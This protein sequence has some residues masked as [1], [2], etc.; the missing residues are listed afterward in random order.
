M[1]L[2]LDQIRRVAPSVFADRPW[3]EVS[4]RYSFIPTLHVVESLLDDGF[5][6]S[7]ARQSRT[8][9]AGKENF[10]KHQLRLR[11]RGEPGIAGEAV[12]E[13]LLQNCHSADGAFVLMAGIFR[14]ACFNG[15]YAGQSFGDVRV[16]H[17]GSIGDVVNA[18]Y[19]IVGEF[20]RLIDTVQQWRSIQLLPDEQM[21]L[22]AKAL[23]LRYSNGNEPIGPEQALW[24]CRP[25]DRGNDLWTVYN[26]LQENLTQGGIPGRNTSGRRTR[27]R[28]VTGIDE[29][30]TLNR[31]LWSLAEGFA[32]LKHGAILEEVAA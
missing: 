17:T 18:T 3:H 31:A 28:A 15:C 11:R 21:L 32:N 14:F 9:T 4:E 13:V 16:R 20:P 6:V 25:E 27:T 23:S 26:R 12:P 29:N 10:V 19:Q 2:T 5:E 22:S 7:S 24:A 1:S 8:H 30:T